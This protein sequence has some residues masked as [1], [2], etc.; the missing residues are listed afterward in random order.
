MNAESPPAVP[1]S[2]TLPGLP[3][4]PGCSSINWKTLRPFSGSS[5]TRFSSTSVEMRPSSVLMSRAC[6]STVTVSPKPPISSVK[7][8]RTVSPTVS[9]TPD[10]VTVRKP[11]SSVV[12]S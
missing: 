1:P 3:V 2:T 11:D 10:C 4:A 8:R 5:L 7:S 6:D 12:T 9:S